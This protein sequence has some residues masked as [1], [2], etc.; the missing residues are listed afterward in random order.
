LDRRAREV[1]LRRTALELVPSR[2]FAKEYERAAQLS[3]LGNAF[4]HVQNHV[5]VIQ[6]ANVI[7]AAKL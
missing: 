3:A 6:P 1:V 2:V 4:D 7:P 5:D